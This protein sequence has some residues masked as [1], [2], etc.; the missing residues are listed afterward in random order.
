MRNINYSKPDLEIPCS[1]ANSRKSRFSSKKIEECH[2]EDLTSKKIFY[3]EKKSDSSNYDR[4]E[5]LK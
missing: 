5:D 1:R 3:V 4:S 2:S